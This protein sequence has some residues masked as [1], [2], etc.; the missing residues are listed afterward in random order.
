MNN[1]TIFPELHFEIVSDLAKGWAESYPVIQKVTLYQGKREGLE[2]YRS[3][4]YVLVVK[5]PEF[6]KMPDLR[7]LPHLQPTSDKMYLSTPRQDSDRE[8]M[9][10]LEWSFGGESCWHIHD[11]LANAYVGEPPGSYELEWGW[12]YM[13]SEDD[14]PTEW[15]LPSRHWILYERKKLAPEKISNEKKLRPSQRH[16]IAVIEAAK[17]IWKQD[18]TITIADMAYRDEINEVCEGKVYREKTIRGW[19]KHECPD[20]SP[21]R[22]SKK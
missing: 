9:R 1:P 19:I 6:V 22:R 20:R 13:S 2:G 4:K 15:I 16:K 12:Y 7:S 5:V 14:I 10:F 17:K 21:G 11:E 3:K 18:P 8:Y